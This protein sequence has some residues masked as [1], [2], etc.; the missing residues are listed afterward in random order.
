M[1]LEPYGG[2]E[3][4]SRTW[5][6]RGWLALQRIDCQAWPPFPAST[7]WLLHLDWRI[8]MLWRGSR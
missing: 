8:Y 7:T 2:G 4:V 6:W 1:I 5:G 3:S